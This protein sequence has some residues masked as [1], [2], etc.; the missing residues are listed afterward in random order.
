VDFVVVGLG[1]GALGV[2]SGVITL[3]WLAERWARAAASVTVPEDRAYATAMATARR[4][5]GQALIGAG[6]AVLIATAGALVGSLDDRTGAYLVTTTVTV[7]SLGLLLRAYLDRSRHPLP[8]RRRPRQTS[9]TSRPPTVRRAALPV[10]S[11]AAV[12]APASNGAHAVADRSANG[13]AELVQIV[14]LEEAPD[15]AP[16]ADVAAAEQGGPSTETSSN[17]DAGPGAAPTRDEPIAVALASA[18]GETRAAAS[19]PR[20][21]DE[22]PS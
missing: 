16:E 11:E 7:A 2:L 21:D 8:P 14:P 9:A 3:G 18:S 1:L 22:A 6:S 12:G 13:A 20:D 4:G 5:L 10:L 17:N 19:P 15:A